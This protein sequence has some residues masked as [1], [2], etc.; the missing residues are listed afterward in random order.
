MKQIIILLLGILLLGY[1]CFSCSSNDKTNN[2]KQ[3]QKSLTTE[4]EK[5]LIALCQLWGFLKYHHPSVAAGE[6][7]WDLELMKLIPVIRESE[8]ETQWKQLLNDWIDRLPS[9]APSTNKKLPDLEIKTKADYGELFNPEYFLP[10]TIDKINYILNNAVILS[11]HYVNVNNI[12]GQLSITNENSYEKLLNPNLSYRLLALFRYWNIINYFFPYRDL[13]DQKW[14]DVLPDMLPKFVYAENQ[15]EYIFACLKL[16]T[17]IDDSHGFFNPQNFVFF[18]KEGLLKV[19]FETQFIENKL[20]VTTY[21]S[22]DDYVKEKIKIGDIITA[23]NGVSVNNLIDEMLPYTPASN[24]A[25]KL[26]NISTKI[27]K[28]NT[29]TV[30]ITISRDDKSFDVKVPRYD[31][32]QLKIPDYFNP[33]PDKEGYQICDNNIGYILPSNCKV[34]DRE[35]GIKKVLNDTKGV[36]IDMRCY[37]SDYISFSFLRHLGYQSIKFSLVSYA[38]ISFPG[39][40][41]IQK[42][43]D[44]TNTEQ[45][46]YYKKKIVVIV[47][48][49]T[50]SQAEDHVLA[51]QLVENVTVI[52][53]TTA[54][55]NGKVANFSLPSGIETYI[56][57]L[58]VYYP[59]GSNLQRVGVKIDEVVKPTISGIKAG[60]DELLERAIEIIETQ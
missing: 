34:E 9:I 5:P 15:E 13:C 48:E 19:P 31:T 58:G 35:S 40:F 52:G 44:Y 39:Y 2:A 16:V 56:T 60:K 33:H 26:R 3:A 11:N 23:I 54:A 10:E 20:V 45:Q 21:T 22:D 59:D 37:P 25:V 4:E 8:N 28:G 14:S 43:P 46:N 18:I 57:G 17:K 53:S 1:S 7:D 29:T 30:D 47:N 32:R 27:L 38:D 6:Y 51:Y 24:Y 42:F 12:S 41:F 49:Y 50:Q 55:A 36:I